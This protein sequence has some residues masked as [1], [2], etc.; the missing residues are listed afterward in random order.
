MNRLAEHVKAVRGLLLQ[1]EYQFNFDGSFGAHTV[2]LPIHRCMSDEW[3]ENPTSDPSHG[4]FVSAVV[5]RLV[6]HNKGNIYL[7]CLEHDIAMLCSSLLQVGRPS[8]AGEFHDFR[9]VA[10]RLQLELAGRTTA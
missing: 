3:G 9:K 1:R 5:E 2:S 7:E 8:Q 6:T 10:P 4:S